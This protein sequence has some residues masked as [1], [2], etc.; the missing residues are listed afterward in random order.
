MEHRRFRPSWSK[1]TEH[2][3][4]V[5]NVRAYFL[6]HA[7]LW[8]SNQKFH[9]PMIRKRSDYY[10]INF[11]LYRN[12]P[13]MFA[14]IIFLM[15]W[16][17]RFF[18]ETIYV[19]TTLERALVGGAM[20]SYRGERPSFSKKH[21]RTSAQRERGE[22]VTACLKISWQNMRVTERGH[23]PAGDKLNIISSYLFS[24]IFLTGALAST[25]HEW[26]S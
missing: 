18:H 17:E 7:N 5:E 20:G 25:L 24:F 26:G 11:G 8:N 9:D 19:N 13:V 1:Y 14:S 2:V 3:P 10:L 15:Y 21:W 6:K 22:K 16:S 4:R 12:I 23:C